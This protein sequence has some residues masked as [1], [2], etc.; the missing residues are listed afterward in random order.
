[1]SGKNLLF[2][3]QL[4]QGLYTVW[5]TD[6]MARFGMYIAYIVVAHS[7]GVTQLSTFIESTVDKQSFWLASFP[8]SNL[9]DWVPGY[10]FS[11]RIL[12]SP[13]PARLYL[14]VD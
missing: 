14:K 2:F 4:K 12:R 3:N 9:P 13:L 1:M 11:R 6:E 10:A 7:H 8:P 5:N